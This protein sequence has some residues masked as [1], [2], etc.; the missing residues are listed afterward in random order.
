MARRTARPPGDDE[1]SNARR[2][3][4]TVPTAMDGAG[5]LR[6]FRRRERGAEDNRGRR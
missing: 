2:S 3:A 4:L 6:R 5:G 1:R